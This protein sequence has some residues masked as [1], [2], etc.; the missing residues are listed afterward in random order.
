MVKNSK[1]LN[2]MKKYE[3][4][5]LQASRNSYKSFKRYTIKNDEKFIYKVY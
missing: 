1:S 3:C 4:N 5:Y 2:K